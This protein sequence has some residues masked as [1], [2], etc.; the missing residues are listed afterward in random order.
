MGRPDPEDTVM[1]DEF[2]VTC[3]FCGEDGLF[4][5]T[6]AVGMKPMLFD[7]ATHTRHVCNHANEFDELTD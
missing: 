3:K 6:L 2:D 1:E 4:W 5:C 7:T